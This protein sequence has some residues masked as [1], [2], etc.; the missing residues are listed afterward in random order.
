MLLFII[1]LS[2]VFNFA[3]AG[4]PAQSASSLPSSVELALQ[5][6]IQEKTRRHLTEL[7]QKDFNVWGIELWV[8]G[9]NHEQL[10]SSWGHAQMRL[11]GSGSQPGR[12]LVVTFV[13]Q[14]PLNLEY[15]KGVRGDYP[16]VVQVSTVE[17]VLQQYV[18]KENRSIYSL[19]VPSTAVRR[20]A[21]IQE[22]QR[23]HREAG[24]N[25]AYYFYGRNCAGV[26]QEVLAEVGIISLTGSTN[27]PA[28]LAR[29]F[30]VNGAAIFPLIKV[31]DPVDFVTPRP[32]A[33]DS[34]TKQW[35]YFLFNKGFFP[36]PIQEAQRLFALGPPP[37]I[38]SLAKSLDRPPS[39][40][41]RCLE[42]DCVAQL[43]IDLQKMYGKSLRDR[44]CNSYRRAGWISPQRLTLLD[45]RQTDSRTEQL[46]AFDLSLKALCE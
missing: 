1:H 28:R 45:R 16:V 41:N 7:E 36:D 24:Q 3:T 40:I 34:I 30:Q 22:I 13:A 11:I 33:A 19:I 6:G 4:Y 29:V 17:D 37:R 9:P 32:T 10:A 44:L 46:I 5:S 18:V 2:L 23:F 27:F 39:V 8:A 20:K 14:T 43:R 26:L 31:I 15:L 21:L 38:A 42:A 35:A 12:D 25:G